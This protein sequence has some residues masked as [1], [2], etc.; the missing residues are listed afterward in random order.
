VTIDDLVFAL[1]VL[2]ALGCGLMAGLFFVFS[3]C[4]MKALARLPGAQGMAA[5]QS[6]NVT[7]LNVAFIV[8]FFGTAAVCVLLTVAA[9]VW[10][11]ESGALWVL[12]GSLLYLIGNVLVTFVFN[13]PRNN[14]LAAAPAT[15]DSA[16]LWQD[17]V[18]T[19]TAWNHVR[20]WACL[21]AQAALTIG[22]AY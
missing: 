1:T 13:V 9:L 6:I 17:Y 16:R 20:T 3:I 19:W 10:W 22:L 11:E 7:I 8:V 4:V 21:G 12:V 18:T 14:A 15:P 5:M 2:A